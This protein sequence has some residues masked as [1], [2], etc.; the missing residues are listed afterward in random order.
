MHSRW[1]IRKWW[2]I[3]K[4]DCCIW[5]LELMFFLS[6]KW[7]WFVNSNIC[8]GCLSI[9]VGGLKVMRWTHQGLQRICF[10]LNFE[11]VA[12]CP[13]QLSK[14]GWLRPWLFAVCGVSG[15]WIVQFMCFFIHNIWYILKKMATHSTLWLSSLSSSLYVE[16]REPRFKYPN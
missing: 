4:A 5:K 7:F 14:G 16:N 13:F 2:E 1:W 15:G 3:A 11:S 12:L 6:L 10:P 8:N 9:L